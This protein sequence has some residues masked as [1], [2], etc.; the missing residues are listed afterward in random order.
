MLALRG[1][2]E[3]TS[4]IAR[5]NLSSGFA[6]PLRIGPYSGFLLAEPSGPI[7]KLNTG[8]GRCRQ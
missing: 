6:K 2:T 5:E 3:P 7:L 4:F 8:I 1:G